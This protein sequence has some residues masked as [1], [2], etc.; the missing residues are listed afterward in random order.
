MPASYKM[1]QSAQTLQFPPHLG[2]GEPAPDMLVFLAGWVVFQQ[3]PLIPPRRHMQRKLQQPHPLLVAFLPV[4]PLLA[5]L[6]QFQQR[7]EAPRADKLHLGRASFP[8]QLDA[9]LLYAFED[10]RPFAAERLRVVGKICVAEDL[11]VK[12]MYLASERLPWATIISRYLRVKSQLAKIWF[13][14]IS[15]SPYS[16]LL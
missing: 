13:T 5:L 2:L 15:F 7:L 8:L 6:P 11:L 16:K 14:R 3:V 9:P 12:K 4:L 10:D 1:S